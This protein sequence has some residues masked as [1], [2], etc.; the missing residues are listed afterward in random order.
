MC[1]H[2]GGGALSEMETGGVTG[3]IM[4]LSCVAEHRLAVD[5]QEEV[6]EVRP[7]A[8]WWADIGAVEGA[9][10]VSCTGHRVWD[11]HFALLA[12]A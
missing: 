3:I 9:A 5:L 8:A 11:L 7:G 2:A 10:V 6:D 12:I 4:L 1:V